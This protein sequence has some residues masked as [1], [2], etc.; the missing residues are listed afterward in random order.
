MQL[1]GLSFHNSVKWWGAERPHRVV[2]QP[3]IRIKH[4]KPPPFST[5]LIE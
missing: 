1:M 5:E 3:G 4:E 2:G